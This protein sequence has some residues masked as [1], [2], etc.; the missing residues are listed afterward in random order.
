[1]TNRK[2]P[3]ANKTVTTNYV[4]VDE[5]FYQTVFD[6]SRTQGAASAIMV[7]Y[8]IS[9]GPK[10]FENKEWLA[11]T[12][13][14]FRLGQLCAKLS[15]CDRARALKIESTKKEA[16]LPNDQRAFQAAVSMWGWVKNQAG[17]PVAKRAPSHKPTTTTNDEATKLLSQMNVPNNVIDF[18]SPAVSLASFKTDAI[19]SAER[20]AAMALK[21]R[22]EMASQKVEGLAGIFEDFI[23]RVNQEISRIKNEKI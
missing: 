16:R 18:A 22:N 10:L 12:A 3:R 13:Q 6:H 4:Q 7:D 5:V 11:R 1:M 8:L 9:A 17:A 2:Q 23:S 15:G 21:A 14:E 20:F 19:T